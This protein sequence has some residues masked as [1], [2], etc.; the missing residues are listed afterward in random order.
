MITRKKSR[1]G[2]MSHVASMLLVVAGAIIMLLFLT[3]FMGKA[4]FEE[5]INTCRFSVMTQVASEVQP[6]LTGKKS[7]LDI[8]CEKRYVRFYEHKVELGLNPEGMKPMAIDFEGEKIKKFSDLTDHVVNQVIA[9]EL[10]IC[11]Y[12][13][14]DGKVEIFGND[15]A[16]WIG[17]KSICFVC[18]EIDFEPTVK[19]KSFNTLV[20]YTNKTTFDDTGITYYDYMT[21]KNMYGNYM[22]KGIGGLNNLNIDTS[23]KY[24]IYIW[25]A[26]PGAI[27]SLIQD[28]DMNI[29]LTPYEDVNKY[30]KQQAS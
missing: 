24:A 17:K 26:K 27:S 16:F 22:W 20:E 13:F 2:Q 9:E 14:A 5:A 15:D 21:E 3:K 25:K 23:K 4:T 19:Q 10:R 28:G 6:G 29:L 1:S 30:C 12:Q 18:A 11:K 8:N 7:P